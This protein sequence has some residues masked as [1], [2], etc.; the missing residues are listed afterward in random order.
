M[1]YPFGSSTLAFDSNEIDLLCAEFL[2]R[3]F[4]SVGFPFIALRG[5]KSV[6]FPALL[7]DQR[8]SGSHFE[9]RARAKIKIINKFGRMKF[10]CDFD[11]LRLKYD[12]F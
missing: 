11:C 6:R 5:Q 7:I 3:P 8:L 2:F 4:F 1:K 10:E 9:T 12:I